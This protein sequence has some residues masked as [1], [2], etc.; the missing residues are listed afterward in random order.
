MQTHTH[1]K[2]WR[3][4]HENIIMKA[5]FFSLFINYVIGVRDNFDEKDIQPEQK[6]IL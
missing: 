6:P 4:H 2:N 5:E 1:L 3:V